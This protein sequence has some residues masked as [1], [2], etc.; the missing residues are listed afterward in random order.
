MFTVTLTEEADKWFKKLKKK[1][2]WAFKYLWTCLLDLQSEGRR[3]PRGK[4]LGEG[5]FEIKT[6]KKYRVY[7]RFEGEFIILIVSAGDKDTQSRDIRK[8]KKGK[9]Q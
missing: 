9:P 2:K 4:S 8:A 5:L 1:D 3:Y 6:P 7:Y